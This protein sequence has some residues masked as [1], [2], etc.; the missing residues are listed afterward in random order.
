MVAIATEWVKGHSGLSLGGL[1]QAEAGI[2]GGWGGRLQSSFSLLPLCP[3]WCWKETL[4]WGLPEPQISSTRGTR[5]LVCCLLLVKMHS[6]GRSPSSMANSSFWGEPPWS[7]GSGHQA[8][9][10]TA[11]P[12]VPP[13]SIYSLLL[14]VP[15][16]LPS[17]ETNLTKPTSIHNCYFIFLFFVNYG[18]NPAH[19][20]F[21]TEESSASCLS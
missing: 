9:H 5:A 10:R 2:E 20:S 18:D 14:F 11:R 12:R 17:W 3:E 21:C 7:E 6:Q 1:Q 15:P 16:H 8:P 4:K 19:L 13:L